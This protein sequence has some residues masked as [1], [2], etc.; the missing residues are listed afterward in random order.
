M[1]A[2]DGPLGWLMQ[3]RQGTIGVIILLATVHPK[4]IPPFMVL[5]VLLALVHIARHFRSI[6]W[7]SYW[8]MLP[9]MAYYLL[10]LIDLPASLSP[11]QMQ[12]AA[13]LRVAYLLAPIA[14]ID[15]R[16]TRWWGTAQIGAGVLIV[17]TCLAMALYHSV[18][19]TDAGLDFYPFANP[20]RAEVMQDVWDCFW[21]GQS[22]FYYA[23]FTMLVNIFPS[24]MG[25]SVLMSL[26][27]VGHRLIAGVGRWK[28]AYIVVFAVLA[29][30]LVLTGSR[31]GYVTAFLCVGATLCYY[32][33]GKRRFRW[34]YVLVGVAAVAIFASITLAQPRMR[35][36]YH[37]GAIDSDE[38]A[39]T[40]PRARL[41]LSVYHD[42]SYYLPWGIGTTKSREY[43][44][45]VL[46]S[47]YD[48]PRRPSKVHNEFI[49][50]TIEHGLSG[51]ILFGAI[52]ILP[53]VFAR[54]FRGIH[55][56]LFLPLYLL[57][58]F[59]SMS[60][61]AVGVA[62]L[63]FTYS[64]LWCVAIWRK[65]GLSDGLKPYA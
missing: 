48:E 25:F 26:I 10:A 18:S 49:E 12:S 40:N 24:F 51:S 42:R 38:L 58:S 57:L 23:E 39:A 31:A 43:V 62:D 59:E 27:L 17:L 53:I 35:G 4:F 41:W 16:P 45:E 22:Y 20:N 60:P 2:C 50:A 6:P 44:D 1:Q 52:L 30:G 33:F 15:L 64:I 63:A 8:P 14:L 65:R 29:V 32:M 54:R 61:I 5:A 28:G 36:L 46:R 21:D 9:M 19:M 56:L 13:M 34:P 47:Y 55:L 11:G 7:R 3:L 37:I